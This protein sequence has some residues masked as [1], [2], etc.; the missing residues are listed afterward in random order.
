MNRT[1]LMLE[2]D[3]DDR[4]ITQS[5]I[6]ENRFDVKIQFVANSTELFNTLDAARSTKDG[7]PTLILINYHTSP[8]SAVEILS[9]LKRDEAIGHIP[10]VVLS[11][12]VNPDAVR[13]CYQA[14]ASSYIRK[15]WSGKDT[16]AK[17]ST[18]IKYWF[19]TVELYSS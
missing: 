2:H 10:V 17:I 14:G 9:K 6:N 5:V 12:S 1:I 19:N 3:E 11:G 13:A 8:L 4:Y 7:L 15:P 16:E 18:F